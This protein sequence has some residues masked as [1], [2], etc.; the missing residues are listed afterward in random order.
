[1]G[2]WLPTWVMAVWCAV[3]AVITILHLVHVARLS[4]RARIWHCGHTVMALGMVDMYW[5]TGSPPIGERPGTIGFAIL[6]VIAALAAIGDRLRGRTPWLW[7]LLA[8]DFAAMTVMF[9][10]MSH[11]WVF[12]T[13]LVTFWCLIEAVA[14]FGGLLN[15]EVHAQHAVIDPT[16]QQD[17]GQDDGQGAPPTASGHGGASLWS[18]RISLGVMALGMA[19]MLLGMQY[20]MG[21]MDMSGTGSSSTSDVSGTDMPGMDMPGMDM[22]GDGQ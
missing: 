5:P 20:G 21:D 2:S 6:A 13:L 8:L 4:G 1:M 17:E 7:V 19:Y 11:S 22:G 3:F 18:V 15:R 9:A 10:L 16:D 14:W 12:L